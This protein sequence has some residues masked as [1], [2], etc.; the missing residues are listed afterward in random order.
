MVIL[1]IYCGE[2]SWCTFSL[3]LNETKLSFY[4]LFKLIRILV[5]SKFTTNLH[6]K[7][8]LKR[9]NRHK[10]LP[11]LDKCPVD[12]SPKHLRLPPSLPSLSPL[13]H[14]PLLPYLTLFSMLF[15][16]TL[17]RPRPRLEFG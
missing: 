4:Y 13:L 12:K 5:T 10:K 14:Y 16:H 9:L 3:M 17:F 2:N 6:G 7:R 8:V 1:S 11:I 15:F